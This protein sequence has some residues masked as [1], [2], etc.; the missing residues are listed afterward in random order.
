MKKIAIII[1]GEPG[2]GKSTQAK[3]LSDYFNLIYFDTGKFLERILFDEKNQ[4]NKLILEQK[5][6]FKSGKLMDPKFVVDFVKKE[7]IKIGKLGFGLV[8]SGSP[9]T[10]YEAEREISLLEK[11]YNKKNIY[12]FE[13][14]L[15]EKEALQR[16][17][18]R[19]I[20]K[21]CGYVLLSKYVNDSI[22]NCPVCGGKFYKRVLDNPSVISVRFKEYKERTTPIFDFI[23]KRG[24]IIKQIDAKSAP[25]K[26]SKEIIKFIK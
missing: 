13:L 14:K 4:K 12:F 26:I 21:F 25:Y 6:L 7:I 9:R 15:D 18:N 2:S 5:K 23:K 24:Y 1:F 17:S 20:C 3:F 22:K 11:I 8:F 10:L 16:N 19:L